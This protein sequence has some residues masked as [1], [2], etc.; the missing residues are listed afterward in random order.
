MCGFDSSADDSWTSVDEFEVCWV[1]ALARPRLGSACSFRTLSACGSGE[2]EAM[3]ILVNI[4]A[5]AE[6]LSLLSLSGSGDTAAK[7]HDVSKD[8]DRFAHDPSG[9]PRCNP[10]PDAP[11]LG[12]PTS[13][14]GED[15][16]KGSRTMP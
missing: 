9:S 5:D 13:D 15:D 12:M 6:G 1:T 11:E 8:A 3:G 16:H 7:G 4:D 14:R 10:S 2:I